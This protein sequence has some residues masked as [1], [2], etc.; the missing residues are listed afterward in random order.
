MILAL[1]FFILQQETHISPPPS[2]SDLIGQS[3]YVLAPITK[4]GKI[5]II[6]E[7]NGKPFLVTAGTYVDAPA[8]VAYKIIS[9]YENWDKFVPTVKKIKPVERLR[10]ERSIW[11]YNLSLKVS[12]LQINLKYYL[13]H[14]YEKAPTRIWWHS[15][16]DY[17][18]D[19]DEV[20]GAW[21]IIPVQQPFLE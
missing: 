13:E 16:D 3:S 1:G 12:I 8:E 2:I 15:A 17:E 20:I 4:S 21:D 14:H 19:I 11:E 9:D 7:K 18:S 5:I 10:E 6:H